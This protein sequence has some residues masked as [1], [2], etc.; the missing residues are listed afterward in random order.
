MGAGNG[1]AGDRVTKVFVRVEEDYTRGIIKLSEL[2]FQ[3]GESICVRCL[4]F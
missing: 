4:V 2:N 1:E 3:R